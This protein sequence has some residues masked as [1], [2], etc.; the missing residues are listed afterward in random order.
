MERE[1]VGT[2]RTQQYIHTHKSR[3]CV[4]EGTRRDLYVV[5]NGRMKRKEKWKKRWEGCR[6]GEENASVTPT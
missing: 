2:R 5:V 4:W 6:G 3:V 1:C